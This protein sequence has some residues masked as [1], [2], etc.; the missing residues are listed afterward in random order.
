MTGLN[1]LA[2]I[3]QIP[4]IRNAAVGKNLQDHYGV[5]A[6][7]FLAPGGKGFTFSEDAAEI[8]KFLSARKGNTIDWKTVKSYYYSSLF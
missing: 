3:V 6:M 2:W 1:V 8:Q 4:L 5:V 7:Q